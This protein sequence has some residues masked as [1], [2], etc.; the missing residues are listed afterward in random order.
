MPLQ[1]TDLIMIERDGV[2]YQGTLS[3]IESLL[4]DGGG[5]SP[6]GAINE[7][8]FNDGAGGFAGA[9]DVE[10]EGGQLRL[11]TIATPTAPAAGGLKFFARDRAGQPWPAFLMPASGEGHFLQPLIANGN[12]KLLMPVSGTTVSNLGVNPA[13]AGTATGLNMTNGSRLARMKRIGYRVTTAA[14]TAVASW[15]DN[16]SQLTIGGG[17]AW[18]GGFWG[19]MHGGPDTGV[20]NASHRFF[21]GLGDTAAPTDVNPSTLL[22]IAGIGYDAADTQV[23]FMHNDGTGAA[24]KIALGASFPKPNAD[25]TFAYRLRLYSPPGA[26]QSLSY[27]VENMGNGVTASGT[28][29]TNLPANT[30]FITPKLYTSVGGTSSVVGTMVGPIMFQTE[31]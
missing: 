23:Q 9:A 10:I 27:E 12:Y 15:R 24:T 17:N 18:E 30:D 29:T 6:G 1:L 13:T 11:P 2:L 28:V 20:T 19:V 5:G 8:Q 7:L 14:T 16:S 22:R 25:G 3:Q 4:G 31:D 21:M 26:T